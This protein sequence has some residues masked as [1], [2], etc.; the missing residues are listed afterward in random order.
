MGAMRLH[1]LVILASAAAVVTSCNDGKKDTTPLSLTEFRDRFFAAFCRFDVLCEDVP[2][3]ATCMA[4]LQEQPGYYATLEQ[5]IAANKVAYDG[6]KAR[7]CVELFEQVPSCKRSEIEPL[8]R[9]FEAEFGENCSEVFTGTVAAGGSCFL[10]EECAGDASCT[11]TDPACSPARQCCAGTCVASLPRVPVGGDC[12]AGSCAQGA[13]CRNGPSGTL[14]CMLPSTVEGSAC[15]SGLC[16]VPLYCDVD[17]TGMGTCKPMVATGTACN[18]MADGCDDGRDT[19][20]STT[21]VCARR[22]RVGETCDPLQYN[23]VRYAACQETTCVKRPTAG[24][25]CPTT[26][27][28]CLGGLTCDAQTGTCALSPV[29]AVCS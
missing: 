29:A 20:D 23:C 25:P 14:T 16:A 22:P 4:S 12:S 21:L 13:F 18:P 1:R 26:G 3:L 28:A 7:R 17:A 11:R 8:A 9:Q 6:V 5:D 19:C 27:P 2:D 15:T 24:E 10:G